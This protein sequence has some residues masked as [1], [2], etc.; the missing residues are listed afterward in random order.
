MIDEKRQFA[1]AK[2]KRLLN[3][4]PERVMPRCP[5]PHF[6]TCGGCQQQHVSITLQQ[7]SK[8]KALSR[9]MNVPVNHIIAG[10]EWG[11]R[12]RVRLGLKTTT[13]LSRLEMCFRMAS[14]HA[15][16]DVHQCPVM[17]PRLD[18]LLPALRDCLAD[19][20]TV[21]QP[22]HVELIMADNGPVMVFRHLTLLNVTDR[23]RLESFS[24]S[25]QLSLFL[26][27]ESDKQNKN[28]GD[29]R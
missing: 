6:A 4:S 20:Q 29:Y 28:R 19:L 12:R 10:P 11:Y 1:H 21:R 24:H 16:V 5:H 7:T 27:P 26:A 18:A 15:L 25:E 23:K 2:I 8:A 9:M 17:A 22:G 14:S 3:H 13:R